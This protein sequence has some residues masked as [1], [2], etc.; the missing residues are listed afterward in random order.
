MAKRL[1][2]TE[3]YKDRFVKSLTPDYKHLWFYILD[4][5]DHAGIWRVDFEGACLYTGCDLNHPE[6]IK[7]FKDKVEVI[8]EDYW[9]IPSFL[10][11][12]YGAEANAKAGVV[13][14]AKKRLEQFGLGDR[15]VLGKSPDTLP[16][17]SQEGLETPK[18]K[19]KSKDK[20]K[21][22]DLELNAF[23]QF[24]KAYP[25]KVAKQDALKAWGQVKPELQIILDALAWQR[26]QEDWVK[27]NGKFIPYPA[28]WLR[29][30]RWLDEKLYQRQIPI[31][32][33]I[34]KT[35]GDHFKVNF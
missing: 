5:C 15:L 18:S 6:A 2:D 17:P 27:D 12:Q 33:V 1:R 25:K 14:S 9:F 24:W 35:L 4:D 10:K 29:D 34:P 26:K 13:I 28:T 20:D 30:N 3:T 8:S 32:R 31:E 16:T 22:K 23:E 7:R 19:N 21:D 11:F